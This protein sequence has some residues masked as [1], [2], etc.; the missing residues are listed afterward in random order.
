MASGKLNVV[1]NE[2]DADDEFRTATITARGKSYTFRELSTEQYDKLVTMSTDKDDMVDRTVLLRLMACEASVEPKLTPN[3]LAKMPY[4]VARRIG[5]LINDMHYFDDEKAD[6][7][8]GD[9][10]PNE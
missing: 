5:T 10:S 9:E 3:R 4:P 2:P 6:T 7:E 8:D 1:Q